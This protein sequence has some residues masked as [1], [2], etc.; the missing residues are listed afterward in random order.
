MTYDGGMSRTSWPSCVNSR[1]QWCELAQASRPTRQGSRRA[2]KPA[3]SLR[4]SRFDTTT[5]PALSAPMDMKNVLGEIETNSADR[6]E[7][8]VR[9]GHGRCSVEGR[10]FD[11]RHLGTRLTL[12]PRGAPSHPITVI[13]VTSGLS[14]SSQRSGIARNLLPWRTGIISA[15]GALH[16]SLFPGFDNAF[17]NILE[18]FREDAQKCVLDRPYGKRRVHIVW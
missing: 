2:K 4:R 15:Y 9:L 16:T 13:Q 8:D 1:A 12:M 3:T 18:I 10:I 17:E 5:R 7:I 11:D 6:G 14:P